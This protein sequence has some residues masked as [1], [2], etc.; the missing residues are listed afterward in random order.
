M[1]SA[2]K[3]AEEFGDDLAVV[4]VEVGGADEES[5]ERFVWKKSWMGTSAMWTT[6][7]PFQTGISTMPS[8]ALL[9]ASGELLMMGN[10]SSM[11]SKLMKTIEEEVEKAK[12]LP[13][14]A[15]KSLKKAYKAFAKGD[16]AK[17][18]EE[19]S[20]VANG[21]DEGAEF[22]AETRKS[23]AKRIDGKFDRVQ[24]MIDN[25]YV[26]EAETFFEDL[27]KGVDDLEAYRDRVT[28]FE[29]LFESDEMGAE[30]DAAKK[31]ARLES[32]LMDDGLEEKL[33]DKV[34][35]FADKFADTKVAARAKAILKIAGRA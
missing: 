19:A 15:P 3:T 9:S 33:V 20:D 11:H 16:Y 7:R 2:I 23:F 1:P 12:G 14:G 6:E 31:F 13:E 22:A 17:A 5:A 25:A 30:L 34:E 4:F 29:E 24:W 28:K 10:P 8:F 21:G 26:L 27:A 35:K 18:L 32:K